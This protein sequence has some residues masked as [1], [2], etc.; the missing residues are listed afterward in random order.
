VIIVMCSKRT[1]KPASFAGSRSGGPFAL[2]GSRKI[3]RNRGRSFLVKARRPEGSSSMILNT[4]CKINDNS[5]RSFISSS[6][7]GRTFFSSTDFGNEG[8]T[9][10]SP[11][12]NCDFS[13]GV[14][15]GRESRN[16][17]VEIKMLSKYALCWNSFAVIRCAG[18]LVMR[19]GRTEVV[20]SFGMGRED[21]KPLLEEGIVEEDANKR[22]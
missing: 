19:R 1:I 10:D 6:N 16:R 12:I 9:C 2:L 17:I 22:L 7:A 14:L 5:S 15:A 3:S 18:L 8:S 21:R 11:R 20:S 13:F 4:F